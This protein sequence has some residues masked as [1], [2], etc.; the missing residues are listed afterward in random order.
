MVSRRELFAG[1]GWIVTSAALGRLGAELPDARGLGALHE[2]EPMTAGPQIARKAD[3]D[4]AP[5][6]V[7]LNGAY[8]HPMPRVAVAGTSENLV[9]N[10]LGITPVTP[11]EPT[12]P[13]IT[14][15]MKDGRE[16]QRRLDAARIN[17]RVSERWIRLS[18]SVYNELHDVDRL[19]EAL[20]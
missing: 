8:T 13:I 15:A 6:Y 12:G 7:Y 20:S 17:A 14:F 4:I 5:D 9:V 18:P 10:G 11:P 1:A 2:R 19:L 16:V 3:F